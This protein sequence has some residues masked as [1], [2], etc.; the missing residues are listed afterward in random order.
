[1]KGNFYFLEKEEIAGNLTTLLG[2]FHL[3]IYLGLFILSCAQISFLALYIPI[4]IIILR[5]LLSC[6]SPSGK[7]RDVLPNLML[8][9]E[10]IQSPAE[11]V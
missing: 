4:I 5:N 3:F 2:N 11:I 7:S 6:V 9:L 10:I 8:L 1:M